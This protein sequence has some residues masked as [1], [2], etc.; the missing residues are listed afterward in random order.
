[1]QLLAV[2]ILLPV[3]IQGR[4]QLSGVTSSDTFLQL[5]PHGPRFTS[6]EED[7]LHSCCKHSDLCCWWQL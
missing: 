3:H 2:H 5:L 6:I 7:R 1:M 4:S